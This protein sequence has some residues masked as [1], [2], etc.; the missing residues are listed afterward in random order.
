MVICYG[1]AEMSAGRMSQSFIDAWGM[2]YD[3]FYRFVSTNKF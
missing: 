3:M 2:Q 1:L